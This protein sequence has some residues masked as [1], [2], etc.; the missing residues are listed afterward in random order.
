[1]SSQMNLFEIVIKGTGNLEKDLVKVTFQIVHILCYG[2][3]L[4]Y[5]FL[6]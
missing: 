5:L 4:H 3:I 6:L 1:M 2:T